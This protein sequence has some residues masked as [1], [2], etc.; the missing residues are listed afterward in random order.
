MP[1][2]ITH[3][4]GTRPAG[5]NDAGMREMQARVYD[6]RNAQYLLIKA[7]PAS[8][9]SRSLMY[10]GLDKLRHQ[11]IRKV[12]VAVPERSIASSF[13]STDLTSS[14]FEADWMLDPTYDLTTSDG[15]HKTKAL[16][17]FLAD[18]G[19]K[20]LL[21]THATLRFAYEDLQAEAFAGTLVAVDEFHHSSADAD[22]KL[23]ELVRGLIAEGSSHVL[24]MT[25]SYFRGDEMMVL[26]PEDEERFT[27]VTF[28]YY[29]QLAGYQHLKTLGIGYTFYDA[30]PNG[31]LDS[32]GKVLDT[33]RK[34]ILHIPSV[35]SAAASKIDKNEQ[36]DRIMDV[37]CGGDASSLSTDERTGFD[38]ITLPDGK[39]YIVAN[40]VDDEP[41]RRDKVITAL[42]AVKGRDELDLIIA[43]GMAKEGFD[44]IWCEH[45]LTVGYRSSM[46]EVVQ[47]I[48]RTTRDA[49]GKE[50]ATFTNFVANPADSQETVVGAVNTFLKAISVALVMENVLAPNFNF[51]TKPP[52]AT[53]G[54]EPPSLNVPIQI[55][56]FAEPS[57]AFSKDVIENRLDEV[58]Q[59]ALQYDPIQLAIL[60]PETTTPAIINTVHVPHVIASLFPDA[61]EEEQKEILHG[62]LANE[63]L[64]AAAN[65][66]RDLGP[67]ILENPQPLL[68][69]FPGEIPADANVTRT[70]EGL[71]VVNDGSSAWLKLSNRFVNLDKLN[72]DL[73]YSINPFERAYEILAKN[74]DEPTLKR[75]HE[76][77]IAQRIP[78][79]DAE[80]AAQFPYIIAFKD[81][82]GRDPNPNA[83]SPVEQRLA[84]AWAMIKE[85]RRKVEAEKAK[86]IE[87]S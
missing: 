81:R 38:H 29:E 67:K 73:I 52:G 41:R 21:C 61:S 28:T 3:A 83:P 6:A 87:A 51:R 2:L 40:L 34:T 84:Q 45:V 50:H 57:T 42:R 56:G 70:A 55:A 59:A 43:L 20:I 17:A 19:A 9:K 80:A 76:A 37:L 13:A 79:T 54:G 74:L 18:P 7:P 63:M 69:M 33:G 27:R 82:E 8:G 39:P 85:R 71:V 4:C 11:G 77:I 31:Y 24:A 86:A 32:I 75:I 26:R 47:I 62:Y 30:T 65:G 25:G 68:S 10:V 72:I 12:I 64:K 5:T 35:N 36:V 66:G 16:A 1:N 15:T 14:G 78:M 60:N 48:G 23:G 58:H 49:P 53:G 44:W 22:N 46:T